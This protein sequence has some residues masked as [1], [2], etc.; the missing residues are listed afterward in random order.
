LAADSYLPRLPLRVSGS[1][2]PIFCVHPAGGLATVYKH[3]ADRIDEA[4]P[5]Y[6]LQERGIESDLEFHPS[7][8][9]M[10]ECYVDAIR[11]VQPVGPYRL[12]G[13][14]LGGAVAQEMARQIEGTGDLVDLLFVLDSRFDMFGSNADETSEDDGISQDTGTP[15]PEIPGISTS[16]LRAAAFDAIL[17]QYDIPARS[18]PTILARVKRSLWRAPQL[19]A[20]HEPG[21]TRSPTVYVRASDNH[22]TDVPGML[23]AITSGSIE[24]ICIDVPHNN[25]CQPESSK[26]IAALIN[27]RLR[28]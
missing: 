24:V 3:L 20:R 9:A 16:G 19:L 6:G 12:L 14:S 26:T 22:H 18:D 15:G 1:E 2:R 7:I 11:S 28:C 4:V 27:H 10:A 25:L 21:L 8:A 5:L 23:A 17:D 13:W